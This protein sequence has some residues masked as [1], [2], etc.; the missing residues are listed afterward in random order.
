MEEPCILDIKI[1]K[2]LYDDD[3]CDAKRERM[4]RK[5]KLSTSASLGFCISGYRM[6]DFKQSLKMVV[7]MKSE[8]RGLHEAEVL[9]T[10]KRFFQAAP[11]PLLTLILECLQRI[12]DTFRKITGRL[13]SCSVLITYDRF[14]PLER[15]NCRVIDFV[16]CHLRAP[17][18]PGEAEYDRNFIEGIDSLIMQLTKHIS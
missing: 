16:H 17:I 10:L 18:P 9:Q 4:I 5:A 12:S 7:K 14:H 8:V 6:V 15:W 1:G 3:A 2:R 13:Y 11:E